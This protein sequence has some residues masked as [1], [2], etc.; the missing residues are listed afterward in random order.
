MH[1][2]AIISSVEVPLRDFCEACLQLLAGSGTLGSILADVLPSF[3][4]ALRPSERTSQRLHAELSS[5]Q[6]ESQQLIRLA[7][8]HSG[9]DAAELVR[10]LEEVSSEATRT[11]NAIAAIGHTSISTATT[12]TAD[13][14]VGAEKKQSASPR[15]FDTHI[16]TFCESV[17]VL[18]E[19]GP[20]RS[21]VLPQ[22]LPSLH[23]VFADCAA[24]MLARLRAELNVSKTTAEQLMQLAGA[25]YGSAAGQL[26]QRVRQSHDHAA[27][28]LVALEELA[29]ATPASERNPQSAVTSADTPV[30]ISAPADQ[31]RQQNSERAQEFYA[32]G[33]QSQQR[34]DF[35][36]AETLYTEALRLDETVRLAWLQRGRIRVMHR[37]GPPAVEDLTRALQLFDTDAVTLRWRADALAMCGRLADALQDY[38]RALEILP[39]DVSVRYN[40]AVVLRV[41]GQLIRA[42][43]EF[44]RLL[45]HSTNRAGTHLNRGLICMARG[46]AEEAVSEFQAALAAKPGL[47]EA[48]ERLKELGVDSSPRAVRPAAVPSRPSTQTQPPPTSSDKP[49]RRDRMAALSLK[50]DDSPPAKANKPVRAPAAKS[51]TV[52]ANAADDGVKH[53]VAMAL[54]LEMSTHE[55]SQR[56]AN[57][58]PD[59]DTSI[60]ILDD[61]SDDGRLPHTPVEIKPLTGS[62]STLDSSS[63]ATAVLAGKSPT[64]TQSTPNGEAHLQIR[65]PSCDERS[66]IRW[67]QLQNGKIIACRRCAKRFSVQSDG[68]LQP[69]VKTWRGSWK[70]QR[71]IYPFWKDHRVWSGL[72]CVCCL[73]LAASSMFATKNYDAVIPEDPKYPKDLAPRAE[74]FTL[75]WLKGDFHTMRQLTDQVQ[76]RELHL[77]AM[78]HPAPPIISA[79]TVERDAQLKVKVIDEDKSNAKVQIHIDGL[80]LAN[81]RPVAEQ[82]QAWRREGELWKFMPVSKPES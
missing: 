43:S 68:Q 77:W 5:W 20:E 23:L 36:T 25:H 57:S 64:K 1:S 31:P 32:L 61:L 30:A 75:A 81:G 54:L 66:S 3:D 39:E 45:K 82:L 8:L 55:I 29:E 51:E 44:E 22:T 58:N 10:G 67:D 37:K 16:R 79:A 60:K 47:P 71:E 80:H 69:L 56:S 6:Q 38:D 52:L 49:S 18:L 12:P 63:I 17:L 41:A 14:Q 65:C 9:S 48:I 74:L 4:Q 19:M 40:R 42:W 70:A 33:L 53:E 11:I 46:Q 35:R 7:K 26:Q 34:G 50:S 24:V 2:R 59:S 21:S 28:M 73:W 76:S 62:V 15:E 78:E 13:E 72:V 27:R